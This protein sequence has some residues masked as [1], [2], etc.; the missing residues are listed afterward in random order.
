VPRPA[1][2]CSIVASSIGLE[3]G[4]E[5]VSVFAGGGGGGGPVV[6]VVLLSHR[7][8]LADTPSFAQP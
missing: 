8:L 4:A 1:R 5:K 6:V 3:I 7:L 2:P